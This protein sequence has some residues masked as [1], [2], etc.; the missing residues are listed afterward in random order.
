MK[1]NPPQARQR[2][3]RQRKKLRI[4]EFQELGFD[5]RVTLAQ[6]LDDGAE[7]RLIDALLSEL[8]EPRRL[9]FG[10]GVRAGFI[11][12][13]DRGSATEADREAL[14]AWFRARPEVASIE[15]SPL[16]DAWHD[17]AQYAL[18]PQA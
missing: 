11:T 14:A 6:A 5:I 12:T 2:S 15:V 18:A 8:I 13:L 4:G 7:A 10:G 17:G 16:Q 1:L 3:R 9:C